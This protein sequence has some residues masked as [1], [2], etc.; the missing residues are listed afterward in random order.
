MR[1]G[2]ELRKQVHSIEIREEDDGYRE[3]VMLT[4]LCKNLKK[5]YNKRSKVVSFILYVD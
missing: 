4:T 2:V 5:L 3:V 1:E